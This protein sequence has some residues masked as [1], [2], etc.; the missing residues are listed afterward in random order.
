MSSLQLQLLT[1]TPLVV[2]I[3]HTEACLKKLAEE[4]LD[5]RQTGIGLLEV[6]LDALPHG[7]QM[8]ET[9]PLPVI[10]TARDPREGGQNNLSLQ[11]RRQLLTAALSW[12]AIIDI[13]LASA[14]EFSP[15]ISMAHKQQREVILSYHDFQTTPEAQQLHDLAAQAYAA[16]A[17]LLKIATMTNSEQELEHLLEFQQCSHPLPVAAMGMGPFGKK[18]RPLL[19][20]AGSA[21]VYGWLYEPLSTMPLSA[22]WSARELAEKIKFH[23]RSGT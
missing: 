2:S 19:A 23:I 9:W 20:T 12:A 3:L 15:I 5:L 11:E 17:T 10:A 8:P 16:G 14:K 4:K 1:P 22:Q 6:R 13:E 21:L 7:F 18:S